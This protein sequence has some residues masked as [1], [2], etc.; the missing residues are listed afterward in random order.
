M[1]A[2]GDKRREN[3]FTYT[4]NVS[5]EAI[6]NNKLSSGKRKTSVYVDDE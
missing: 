4:L 3:N 5:D 6:I 2:E 1:Q